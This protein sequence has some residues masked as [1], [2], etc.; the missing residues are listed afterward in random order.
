MI[1]DTD[2]L[3]EAIREYFEKR[4][5]EAPEGPCRILASMEAHMHG[6]LVDV[7]HWQRFF[8]ERGEL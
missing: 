4:Q 7:E 6:A 5:D 8:V 3:S 2:K 1:V